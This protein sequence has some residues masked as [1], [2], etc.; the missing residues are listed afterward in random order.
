MIS[1]SMVAA[2]PARQ[3]CLVAGLALTFGPAPNVGTQ[4]QPNA[5]STFKQL[6]ESFSV[7]YL[8]RS[9]IK[10][11][12]VGTPPRTNTPYAPPSH[13]LD[14]PIEQTI[15]TTHALDALRCTAHAART[16]RKLAHPTHAP[17]DEPCT[18]A[19]AQQ[20]RL[21]HTIVDILQACAV[22]LDI[23]AHVRY[24]YFLQGFVASDYVRLGPLSAMAHFGCITDNK[25]R[26]LLASSALGR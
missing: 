5:S 1:E 10:V 17:L 25:V 24:R 20:L 12:H 4:F 9:Y 8:D 6:D 16:G 11:I 2:A 7:Q 3:L 23:W 19:H 13:A 22:V 26:C 18:C 21:C 14:A 15:R